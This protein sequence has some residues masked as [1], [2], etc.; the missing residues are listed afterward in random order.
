M[1]LRPEWTV[2][3]RDISDHW[4]F[5]RPQRQQYDPQP[6]M[7]FPEPQ[8]PRQ[9]AFLPPINVR[10]SGRSLRDNTDKSTRRDPVHWEASARPRQTPQSSQQN[11]VQ[12]PLVSQGS[13]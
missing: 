13:S 8:P 12:Q 10:S 5:E 1:T 6:I 7:G 3:D 4:Y 2:R 9:P 11:A